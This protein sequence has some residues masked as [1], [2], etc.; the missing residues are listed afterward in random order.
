MKRKDAI[1]VIFSTIHSSDITVSTTGLISREVFSKF[2]SPRNIYIPGSMGLVSSIGLSLALC[3]DNKKIFIIDGDASLLMNFGSLVTIGAYKPNNLVHIV[4]DNGAYGSCSEEK[5]LSSS[6][7]FAKIAKDV[8][9]NAVFTVY[10]VLELKKSIISE[11]LGPI[12]IHAKIKL[13]GRRDFLRPLDLP[14]LKKRFMIFLLN[15]NTQGE[16]L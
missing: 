13:G 4:L 2:D 10:T 3:N 9:F 12:F 6:A 1:E 16:K 7:N 8:G 15:N 11:C 14:E 5:S